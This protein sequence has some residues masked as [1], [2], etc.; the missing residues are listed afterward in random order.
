VT[1]R[2]AGGGWTSIVVRAPSNRG[3]VL[4]A[5]FSLGAEGVQEAGDDLVTHLRDVDEAAARNMLEGT[6]GNS[7]VEFSPT[8]DVDWSHAWRSRLSAHRVGGL[9]VT[10]PWLPRADD[11]RTIVIDPEMAF[12]TG[13]HET[14]RGVLRLMQQVIR[15]GDV[16]ADLGAGSAVLSIA[17]AKLGARRCTAIELDADAI[18]N[19]EFNVTANGVGDR[20]S[21]IEGD[22]FALL[23]LIA[24]VRVVLAN[25]VASVLVDLLPIV[26][27]SLTPG[28]QAIISGILVEE[29]ARMRAALRDGG[30]RLGETDVEGIW[31]SATIERP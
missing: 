25:I 7:G 21:V 13:D 28:G 29:E 31:W 24:P 2:R 11:D 23:P 16:V 30:W 20:V 22:A 8:P 12:G 10:P 19:A 17:A 9:V 26:A 14:T 1:K 4:D 27:Q 15:D 3:A 5:L 18:G 6:G